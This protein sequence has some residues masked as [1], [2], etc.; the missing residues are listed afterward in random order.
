MIHSL[1]VP[2]ASWLHRQPAVVK[3]GVLMAAGIMLFLLH[4]PLPL[5]IAAGLALVLLASARVPLAR[6]WAQTRG[7]VV[8]IVALGGVLTLLQGWAA[9]MMVLLRLCALMCLALAVTFTTRSA[10]LIAACERALRPLERR[11]WANAAKVSLA[12]ALALRFMPEIYRRYELIR[13]AQAARGL[14]AHPVRLI[15]PLVISVLKSADEIAEAIEARGFPPT[16]SQDP[17]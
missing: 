16:R 15:V 10:D 12:L 7:L 3:L 13:E 17:P 6:I 11:G 1:Y 5:A 4:H 2:G 9:T 8:L 14:R